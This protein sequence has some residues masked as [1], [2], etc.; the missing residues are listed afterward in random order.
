M[1]SPQ[2]LSRENKIK[3]FKEGLA[4]IADILTK[5]KSELDS[6][7]SRHIKKIVATLETW[8]GY[9]KHTTKNVS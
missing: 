6:I 3:L 1:T 8:E 9:S 7:D 2:T 5:N 4:L